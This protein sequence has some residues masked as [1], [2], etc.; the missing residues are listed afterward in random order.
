MVEGGAARNF[1]TDVQ[2]VTRRERYDVVHA[3]L[4]VPGADVY[5]LRGGT[6]PGQARGS[7]RRRSAAGRAVA[8]AARACNGYRRWLAATEAR[9]A[10]DRDTCLLAVSE[11]VAQEVREFYGRTDNVRVVYNAVD[12][13]AVSAEERADWRQELRFRLGLSSG[14]LLLLT[15]ATNFEIKGVRETI[16]AVAAWHRK[17]SDMRAVL[18]VLGRDASEAEGYVRLAEA[19]SVGLLVRFVPASREI[20]RWYSAADACMLLSRYDPC[21][22]VVLE[23][24]RWGVPSITTEFNGAAEAIVD[25][26]GIVVSSPDATR[27]VLGAMEVMADAEARVRMLRRCLEI[28]ARL[29]ME[30]HVAE[31]REVYRTL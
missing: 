30:R 21:S 10:A 31:L 19:R 4:P 3:M 8:R 28:S 18:V 22:R 6:V 29:S 9:V 25:G 11:M 26:A 20:F 13:P 16:G 24:A 14:D 7:S 15:A 23:A 2:D 1:I 27:E 5:Q 17:W 12:V